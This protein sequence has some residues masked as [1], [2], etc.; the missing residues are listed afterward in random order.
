MGLFFNCRHILAVLAH[1]TYVEHRVLSNSI[2]LR[3]A[4]HPNHVPFKMQVSGKAFKPDARKHCSAG[5]FLLC[6]KTIQDLWRWACRADNEQHSP[7]RLT[8]FVSANFL[9]KQ[10]FRDPIRHVPNTENSTC[11]RN[12][13]LTGQQAGYCS[14]TKQGKKGRFTSQTN[15]S[16]LERRAF[17]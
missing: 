2:S 14:K 1:L 3:Y 15:G 7:L 10:Q 8:V 11:L 5:G 16:E 13:L 17:D 9:W 6:H 12:C 4:I